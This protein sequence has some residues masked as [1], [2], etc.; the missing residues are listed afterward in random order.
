MTKYKIALLAGDGVGVDICD[1][2]KILFT[3]LPFDFK[4]VDADIGYNCW[5]RTNDPLPPKTLEI[6]K[7]TDCAFL[8]AVTTKIPNN[9][10]DSS[11]PVIE[12]PDFKQYY[13]PLHKLYQHLNLYLC[14]RPAKSFP[15]NPLNYRDNI[16]ITVFR[17]STEG[18]YTGLEYFPI[19]DDLYKAFNTQDIPTNAAISIR[20]I[21][22]TA[23]ERLIKAAFEFAAKHNK[24]RITIVHKANVLKVTDGIF[25]EEARS[26]SKGYQNIQYEEISIDSFCLALLK[27]PSHFNVIVTTNMFGDIISHLSCQLTGGL[28]FG[29]TANIGEDYAVFEPTHGSAPKYA[30]LYKVNPIATFNAAKMMLDWLEEY[31]L[32]LLI[33]NAITAVIEEGTVKT[34]DMGGEDSTID[35]ANAIADKL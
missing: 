29:A 10:I 21:T 1:A 14:V 22:K 19:P 3:R 24:D 18:I 2:L 30:G 7:K 34:Y 11:Q 32:A 8:G 26:V 33:D 31:K 13:N 6:L 28:G 35:M 17:E 23:S 4:F 15:N 16:D 25:L 5:K 27:N 20:S 12:N 9:N